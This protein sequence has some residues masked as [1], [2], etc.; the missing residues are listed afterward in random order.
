M[1]IAYEIVSY[2]N[3]QFISILKDSLYISDFNQ[4]N[5]NLVKM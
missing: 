3:F 5:M 4:Q 1:G 2:C